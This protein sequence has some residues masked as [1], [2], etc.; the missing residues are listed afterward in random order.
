MI[1]QNIKELHH[2]M[3]E[4]RLCVFVGAGVSNHPETD[5]IKLPSWED[6]I[7]S[8][9]VELELPNEQDYLKLAQLYYLQFGEFLYYKKLKSFFNIEASP[10]FVHQLIL[11]LNPQHIITTNWDCLLEKKHFT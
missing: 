8:F 7:K 1:N 5:G 11:K 6:L 10:S 2:A 4:Q 3:N 9:Q